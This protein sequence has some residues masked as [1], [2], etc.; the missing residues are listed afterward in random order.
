MLKKIQVENA[1]GLRLAHDLTR[2]VPGFKGAAFRRGH[3]VRKSDIPK[4]LDLGKK[5]VYVLKLERGEIHEDQAARR[6]GRAL[7]GRGLRLRGPREGK[8]DFLTKVSGLLKVNTSALEKI[9]SFGS[10]IVSTRHNRTPTQ[11][12]EVVGGTR[13]IPLTIQEAQIRKIEEVGRKEGPVLEIL[14][15]RPRKVGVIV[16]GSEIYEKRIKDRSAAIV[17]GK[18]EALGSRVVREVVVPDEVPRIAEVRRMRKNGCQVIIATGGLSVDPD[19]VTLAGIRASGA[20][21]VFYGVPVLPGSM[22]AYAR[23][24]KTVILGAPACVVHDPIT[25]LDL[26]L[27]RVL[28]GDSISRKEIARLGHGGLCW[29]CPTCR[30][31]ICPMGKGV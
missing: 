22:T 4:L 8:I 25:A 16:T 18:V 24:G 7:A 14:P 1:V 21:V 3:V 23:L 6:L 12:G 2:I 17:R 9:N 27:P 31:P 5:Q 26:F 13:I 10:V 29:K 28:A 20:K 15:F 30:F 19:D 11:P